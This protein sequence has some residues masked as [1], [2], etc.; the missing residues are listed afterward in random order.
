MRKAKSN[1]RRGD[2]S[3]TAMNLIRLRDG[4]SV[5][6]EVV[7]SLNGGRNADV[8]PPPAAQSLTQETQFEAFRDG[9]IIDL[10]RGRSGDV[11]FVVWRNGVSTFHRTFQDGYT[12]LVPPKVH[13]SFGDALRLPNALGTSETART[14]LSE[15]D[16][17][18][19][20]YLDLDQS[21]RKLVAYFALCT[22]L[23]GLLHTAPYLWIIGPFS[24]GKTTLLRLLSA[25]CRRSIL[26]GDVSA[27]ALYTLTSTLLPTLLLD[28]FDP[29][30]DAPNRSLMRLLRN[31][32]SQGQ[33]VLRD[34]R[35]YDVFGPKVLCSRQGVGDAA[36]AS[37]GLVVAMR[38]P[39]RDL[40][41]LD[42][43]V[44]TGIA[45]RLQPKL[46]RFRLENYTRVKPVA[47]ASS[48]LSPRMRDIARA[49]AL[50][51]LGDPE[52]EGELL[53]IINPHDAQARTDRYGEPE[54]V[55]MTALLGTIH[56]RGAGSALLTVKKL[57]SV[58]EFNLANA[59][60]SYHLE[61]R[62]VGEI[63]RSLGFPTE[64]LGSLGR[65]L[66]IS[67]ELV[68]SIHI[69]ARNLGIC[70]ADTHVPEDIVEGFGGTFEECEKEGFGGTCRDCEEAGL[71]VR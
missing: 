36:L 60:E 33:N 37:R 48:Y 32:S 1:N 3:R 30:G 14:L 7:T 18:L 24:V 51:L 56:I 65:G 49:L 31:G 39:I 9:T 11:G 21:D 17:L 61:P 19:G 40:P 13:R 44:L 54:W 20:T 53:G 57:T 4:Q 5:P 67:R 12:T 69:T 42:P 23:N 26:A 50:P 47:L 8:I 6:F 64:R 35:A 2:Q 10:I 27:A 45:D 63:L 62:K 22:W 38:P 16:E 70:R 71:I 43:D 52:L 28:E 68:R 41:P 55:V 58:V 15:I 29:T 34:S 66:R 25:I 59:G 46:L